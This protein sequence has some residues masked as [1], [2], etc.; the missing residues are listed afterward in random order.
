M[1]KNKNRL[2]MDLWFDTNHKGINLLHMKYG[3]NTVT[4][5][6]TDEEYKSI[7]E[8]II[9]PHLEVSGR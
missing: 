1:N 2:V 5:S 8:K 6:V 4:V 9:V 7:E 3:H